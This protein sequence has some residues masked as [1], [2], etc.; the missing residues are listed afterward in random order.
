MESNR[1]LYTHIEKTNLLLIC[2]AIAGPFF[3]LAWI[4]QGLSRSNYDSRQ[5]AISSLSVGE[6]GW[7]Q[8]STFIITGLLILAF[9][10]E[11]RRSLQKSSFWGPLLIG[12]LGVGL[13]GSG[14]FVTDPL[15]GYPPGTPLI[16]TDRTTQGILHDLFGIPVFLGLPIACLVFA[17]WFARHGAPHWASYSRLSGIGMFV[18]FF[19]AR[20]GFRLLPGY[21]TLAANFGLLQRITVTIGFAWLTLLAIYMMKTPAEPPSQGRNSPEGKGI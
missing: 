11:L 10:I 3:T 18:V 17:R 15:N 6:F 2:G 20:L 21:P 16:P 12:L 19:V 1:V 14:I 8:I 9:S 4:L 13:V 5:H 7:M